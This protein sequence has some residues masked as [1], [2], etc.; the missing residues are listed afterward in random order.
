MG[1]NES[2]MKRKNFSITKFNN[3]NNEKC[4]SEGTITTMS[5]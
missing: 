5:E 4:E 1:Y 3:P 2:T